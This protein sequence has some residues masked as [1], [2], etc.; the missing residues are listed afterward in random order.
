MRRRGLLVVL[1]GIIIAAS[2]ALAML[3]FMNQGVPT[4]PGQG[5]G[6]PTAVPM[7]K[8]M[9][10]RIDIASNTVISD[11]ESLLR[12]KDIP[13]P[14]Y[15][16]N[17]KK[18][19]TSAAELQNKMTLRAIGAG[20]YILS[21]DITEP[22]LSLQIPPAEPNQ[23]RKKALPLEVNSL[24]GVADEIKPGDY[25]DVLASFD[26][27]RS[28]IRVT[29]DP[30]G[31]P[32]FT[33]KEV[34]VHSTKTLVQNTQVLKILK[35]RAAPEGTPT[36]GGQEGP[37]QTDS[38]GQPVSSEQG[39]GPG[40]GITP[41]SWLLLL[42]VND[43]EAEIIKFSREAGTGITLVLRGRG[44]TTVETTLGVTID[45]LANQFG[46][47]IGGEILPQVISPD[48]LTP[49]P[50]RVPITPPSGAPTPTP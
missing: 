11:T 31:V 46:L 25:V 41:G 28:V 40:P 37:P 3:V 20:E 21:D 29:I 36:P 39:A 49:Q 50:T 6:L 32:T 17:P 12:T 2:V 16:A 44:D 15:N 33:E 35:P 7:K 47:P 42:A 45:I 10:A 43:Q 23:P 48:Q 27:V 5:D 1:L 18:Y 19:F 30:Q 9:V 34:T 24:T 14:D 22:G 13:E 26:I 38:S 4:G 8:V